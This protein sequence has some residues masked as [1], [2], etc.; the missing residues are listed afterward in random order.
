MF[1]V[2]FLPFY[3]FFFSFSIF[4]MIIPISINWNIDPS[5][6]Y[7]WLGNI[8]ETYYTGKTAENL[9]KRPIVQK[10]LI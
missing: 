3:Y 1:F 5:K 6:T 7:G 10:Y 8:P 2:V 4:F 9:V